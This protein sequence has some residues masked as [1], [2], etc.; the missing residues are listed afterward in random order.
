MTSSTV[1]ELRKQLRKYANKK[2]AEASARFFKTGKGEYGEGDVFIGVA[3]PDI[4]AVAKAHRDA[5]MQTVKTLLRSEIHEE[6]MLALL[7]W[8]YQY[9]KVDSNT[10]EQIYQTYLKNRKYVNNWDLIDVTVPRTI[11]RHI[12][13]GHVDQAVLDTLAHSKSLWDRRIAILATAAFIQRDT[14]TPTLRIARVLLKDEHDLIHKAVGWMLREVGKRDRT[15][16]ER[17]LRDHYDELHRTTL[18][19][20]IERFPEKLR[21]K[22]LSGRI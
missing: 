1:A 10:R 6:R 22:Y 20:A 16:L 14:F 21:K 2:R 11:G 4:R 5:S 18:R 13:D 17:F 9:E 8:T 12:V 7:I 3:M 19:Y 15:V